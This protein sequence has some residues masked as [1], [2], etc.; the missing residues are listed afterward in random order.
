[1]N[2]ITSTEATK[3]DKMN[4]PAAQKRRWDPWFDNT[5]NQLF[6]HT[7]F[8]QGNNIVTT[9]LPS[10]YGKMP[11]P[12]M[13]TYLNRDNNIPAGGGR[14]STMA[15]GN[16]AVGV[17]AARGAPGGTGTNLKWDNYTPCT[18]TLKRNLQQLNTTGKQ[19]EANLLYSLAYLSKET[20]QRKSAQSLLD[21]S[22][23]QNSTLQIHLRS[24]VL[25]TSRKISPTKT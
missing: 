17:A 20:S 5:P 18:G 16:V 3:L 10:Q 23:R 8:S 19:N 13:M 6:K 7:V 2:D 12:G 22:T 11:S 25:L 9:N 1:M 4:V 15:A 14:W 21:R 24:R